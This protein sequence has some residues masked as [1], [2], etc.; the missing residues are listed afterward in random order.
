MG[1]FH[2]PIQP[3][4]PTEA[5]VPPMNEV[6]SGGLLAMDSS[7]QRWP[8]W[9]PRLIARERHSWVALSG[10]GVATTFISYHALG[11]SSNGARPGF[12]DLGRFRRERREALPGKASHSAW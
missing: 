1:E 12:R 7:F 9:K 11:S 8:L 10:Q 2:H 5:I 6:G 4:G 3:V